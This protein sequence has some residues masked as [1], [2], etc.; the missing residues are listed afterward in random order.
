MLLRSVSVMTVLA[1]LGACA[2][3]PVY[4]DTYDGPYESPYGGTYGSSYGRSYDGSSVGMYD[5]SMRGSAPTDS[6]GAVRCESQ[7]GR[8]RECATGFRTRARLLNNLSDTRCVEGR[9]WGDSGRGSVWVQGGCRGVFAEAGGYSAGTYDGTGGRYQTGGERSTVRCES[10]DGRQREC[11]APV[12]RGRVDLVRQLS[13]TRCIEGRNWGQRNGR[14]WVSQG[15]RGE[16]AVNRG[17]GTG[18]VY[19]AGGYG[20]GGYSAGDGSAYGRTITCASESGRT[21]TCRWDVRQGRPRLLQ[22][23][24]DSPCQEGLSWGVAQGGD[25]W[26]SRGCRGRFGVR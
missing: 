26:V 3:M 17:D 24:S 7:D 19:E 11:A 14:I 23:L 10:D 20:A 25:V 18:G 13:D 4:S 21:T 2:P 12:G 6:Q 15:C 1:L 9:N 5:G 22:Q 8:R 16:F